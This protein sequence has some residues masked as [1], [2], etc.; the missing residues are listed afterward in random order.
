MESDGESDSNPRQLSNVKQYI[1][2]QAEFI[3]SAC[4]FLHF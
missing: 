4:V 2:T 3:R 1:K